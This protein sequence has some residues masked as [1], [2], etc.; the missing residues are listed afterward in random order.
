MLH[1]GRPRADVAPLRHA[2]M[3]RSEIVD[4]EAELA[5]ARPP[6]AVAGWSASVVEP[7]SNSV[8]SGDSKRSVKPRSSRKKRVADVMSATKRMT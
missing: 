2:H 5:R 7:V 8:Q 4:G 6:P 1:G 3:E